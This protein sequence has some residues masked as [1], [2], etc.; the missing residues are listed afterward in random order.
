[1]LFQ[2]S[3]SVETCFVSECMVNFGASSMQGRVE[4]IFYRV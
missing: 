3:V 2:I 1:M 4:D